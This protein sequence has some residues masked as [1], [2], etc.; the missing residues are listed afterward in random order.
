M[1]EINQ[2]TFQEINKIMNAIKKVAKEVSKYDMPL[3]CV[4]LT[5]NNHYYEFTS[6]GFLTRFHTKL[7]ECYNDR[8][9]Y[10]KEDT[11]DNPLSSHMKFIKEILDKLEEHNK[12]LIIQNEEEEV[13][14]KIQYE[15]QAENELK[16]QLK[17]QEDNK[18]RMEQQKLFEEEERLRL[19]MEKEKE[20]QKLKDYAL[21]IRLKKTEKIP[22]PNCGQLKSRGNMAT[23]MNMN[24]C[25]NFGKEI[26]VRKKGYF[27]CQ[28]CGKEERNTNRQN[29]YATNK[30]ME[31]RGIVC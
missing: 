30:C 27:T 7:M 26:E 3:N 17:I 9:A 24:V 12:V 6:N 11:I 19:A 22:C 18:L 14:R 15:I 21:K 28:Y 1:E 23:H 29:H 25:K 2:I 13:K 4:N 20:I 5:Y 16:K 10:N 8:Y 31:K